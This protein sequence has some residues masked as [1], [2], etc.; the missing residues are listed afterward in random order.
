MGVR[1]AG[2]L[3]LIVTCVLSALRPAVMMTG[4]F[5]RDGSGDEASRRDAELTPFRSL[6]RP[7]ELLGYVS[8]DS[9]VAGY[10]QARYALVPAMVV[11]RPGPSRL[12]LDLSRPDRAGSII[13]S[14][15]WHPVARTEHGEFVLLER[16]AAINA[17]AAE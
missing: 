1:A 7:G 14:T 6:I 13:D 16:G 15:L 9:S 10:Y 11:D 5:F 4:R 17:G 12:I 8:D 2:R 3:L